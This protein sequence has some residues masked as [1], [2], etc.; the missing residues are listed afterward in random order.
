MLK[1]ILLPLVLVFSFIGTFGTAVHADAYD[2]Y[3][4]VAPVS[5]NLQ[6]DD[7]V[8]IDVYVDSTTTGY[9]RA[10]FAYN[11]ID[12]LNTGLQLVSVNTAGSDFD[13]TGSAG[14]DPLVDPNTPQCLRIDRSSSLPLNG[15]HLLGSFTF[16]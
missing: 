1:R 10:N 12:S 4:Q 9:Q 5:A 13:T 8:S 3:F 11:Y 14:L 6:V 16:K 7:T 15:R 2:A